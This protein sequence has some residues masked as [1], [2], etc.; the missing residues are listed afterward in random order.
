[1]LPHD[2]AQKRSV[3]RRVCRE[4]KWEIGG[5]QGSVLAKPPIHFP[6]QFVPGF[7]FRASEF[8]VN[9]GWVPARTSRNTRRG[10]AKKSCSVSLFLLDQTQDDAQTMKRMTARMTLLMLIIERMTEKKMVGV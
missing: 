3:V 4:P 6:A 10:S 8:A 9:V 5:F 1:M 7:R 2:P